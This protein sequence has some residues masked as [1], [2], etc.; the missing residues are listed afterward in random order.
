MHGLR[1]F[2]EIRESFWEYGELQIVCFHTCTSR[3]SKTEGLRQ[4]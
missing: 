2:V 3:S 1:V 4:L